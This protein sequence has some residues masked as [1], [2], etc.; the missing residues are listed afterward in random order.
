M[1]SLTP[2]FQTACVQDTTAAYSNPTANRQDQLRLNCEPFLFLC[3]Y[4]YVE[5]MRE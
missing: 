1:K 2:K 4:Y 3:D 5:N